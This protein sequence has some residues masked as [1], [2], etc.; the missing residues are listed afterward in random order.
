MLILFVTSMDE[1]QKLIAE[2]KRSANITISFE[3][4]F[5][6]MQVFELVACL[7]VGR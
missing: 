2:E 5:D 3:Q 1:D 7:Q 4:V 6:F